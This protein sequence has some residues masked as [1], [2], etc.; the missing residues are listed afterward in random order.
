VASAAAVPDPMNARL[1]SMVIASR[2]Y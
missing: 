2:E 1:V